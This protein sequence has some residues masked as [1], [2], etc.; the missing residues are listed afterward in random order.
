[1]EPTFATG[2]ETAVSKLGNT[3]LEWIEREPKASLRASVGNTWSVSD[4]SLVPGV[5]GSK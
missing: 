3:L 1:M 5:H 2:K 4:K